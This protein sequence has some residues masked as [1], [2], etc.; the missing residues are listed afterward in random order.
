MIGLTIYDYLLFP[1]YFYIILLIFKKLR[2]RYAT[3]DKLYF[4]FTWGFRI[5]VFIIVVYTLLSHYVI[6]GDAVDLYYGEGKHFAQLIKDD[7][8]KIDLLFTQGGKEVDNL[9]SPEEKGYLA[10]ETNY[11]VV[12]VSTLLCFITFSSFLIINLVIGFIAFL[13]SWQLYLF[14]L[15]QYPKLHKEFA[16]ACMGI[17][18]VIFWSAGIS[19]DT[20]CIASLSLL[21]K[22]LYDVTK[23]NKKRLRNIVIV[24]IAVFLIYQIKSYIILSYVPFFLLFLIISKINETRIPL[25]RYALKLSI[26]VLFIGVISYV[27]AN[28]DELFKE[29]SSDKILENI[30]GKQSAFNAQDTGDAGSFFSLGEFDGSFSGI[31]QLAPKAIVATFFRPFIWESKN[32]IMLLSSM[33][34]MAL[35]FFT[36][37]VLFKPR[38]VVNFFP[39]IFS[40]A[41]VFFCLVFSILFAVFVGIS[42][43]NFGSLVRYKIPCIPFYVSA[44]IVINHLRVQRVKKINLESQTVLMIPAE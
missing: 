43:Y 37:Y 38:G 16:F 42:T 15:K 13:G 9:A 27:I 36:L 24:L 4:Y 32:L 3:N 12:K 28:S 33:E 40:N 6:R 18:T 8:S 41:L 14:F 26:P 30:S 39:A 25:F 10:M 11:M 17:P 22:C 44:L 5:K 29:Y 21:T 23:T 35:L 1:I 34:A 19:K 2:A 7:P 31:I 20:I